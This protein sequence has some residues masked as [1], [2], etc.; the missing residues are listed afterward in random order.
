MNTNTT[1]KGRAI[2]SEQ[3]KVKERSLKIYTYLVCHA[4]LRNAPN[5]FGDNVR[6]F[7]QREINMS[8]M[9]KILK[10]DHRTVK[11]YW[12]ELESSRL[13]IFCPHDWREDYSL[14]FEERWKERNKHKDTYYEIPTPDLFR[15]IPK[16][17]LKELVEEQKVSELT[18]KIYITLINFQEDCNLNGYQYKRFTYKDIQDILGHKMETYF[19]RQVEHSINQ[20]D[21]L[22]LLDYDLGT[23]INEYGSKIPV[24][25]VNSVNFY[26]D[27]KNKNYKTG[28]E[29]VMPQD[30]I[31]RIIQEN[32]EYRDCDKTC[33]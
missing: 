30:Q 1:V 19:N 23:Y 24:Y 8:K 9:C 14:S 21:S 31:D 7:K 20:L 13:I 25:V 11:K 3:T 10:M 17:T 18:L 16:E 29:N 2:F 33:S 4:D 6:I 12:H 27:Y 22:G 15:K 26:I 28:E 32:A 5:A